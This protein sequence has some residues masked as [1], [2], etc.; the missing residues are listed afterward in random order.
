MTKFEIVENL[1]AFLQDKCG[2]VL[3][4]WK[5]KLTAKEQRELFGVYLGKGSI[6]IDGGHETIVHSVKVCFGLDYENTVDLK[7]N[8]FAAQVEAGVLRTGRI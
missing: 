6:I 2:S 4:I 5:G 3:R 8:E 1:A 7:W